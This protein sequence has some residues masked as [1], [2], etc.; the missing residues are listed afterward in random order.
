MHQTATPPSSATE[1]DA[2]AAASRRCEALTALK[3]E[4]LSIGECIRALASPDDDLFIRKARQL[5]EGDDDVVFESHE[6]CGSHQ[7]DFASVSVDRLGP[8]IAPQRL[9]LG[10][11]FQLLFYFVG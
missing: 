2:K 6:A 1:G 7:M 11:C 4:G 10:D 8:V 9:R 5:L 3:A